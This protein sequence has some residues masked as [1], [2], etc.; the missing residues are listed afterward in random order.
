MQSF[1]ERW[2]GLWER[3]G[4]RGDPSIP[5]ADLIDRY[6]E[7]WRVHHTLAHPEAMFAEF[8]ECRR[9]EEFCFMDPDAVEMAIFYHDAV[10]DT[11]ATDNEEKSAELFLTVAEWSNLAESFI[12]EVSRIILASKHTELPRGVNCRVLCD[13]DLAILGQ[14]E[15]VFDEYDCRI[16]EEYNWVPE[17]Q[18][19]TGRLEI[20]EGFLGRPFVY[21]TQFF[22]GKYGRQARMNLLRSMERLRGS[23]FLWG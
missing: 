22:R 3:I 2:Y 18:F 13:I 14:P 23:P 19:R 15:E 21:S 11:R 4:A 12:C 17:E 10:Y 1:Q 6:N 5:L 7:P 8:D 9:S 16:R 20:M